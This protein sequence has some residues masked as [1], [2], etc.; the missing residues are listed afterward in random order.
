MHLSYLR[1]FLDHHLVGGKTEGKK[2]RSV[3]RTNKRERLTEE[4][5]VQPQKEK[6]QLVTISMY[7]LVS[8]HSSLGAYATVCNEYMYLRF[9]KRLIPCHI[10][11]CDDHMRSL[12]LHG[13]GGF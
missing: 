12:S 8:S 6:M 11:G 2:N 5:R 4:L 1:D 9:Y 7:D 13:N 3:Y 10:C